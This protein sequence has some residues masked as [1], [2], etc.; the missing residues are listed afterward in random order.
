MFGEVEA[1]STTR[2][3]ATAQSLI[4]NVMMIVV[5]RSLV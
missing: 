2:Q 4:C 5:A 1:R 3:R